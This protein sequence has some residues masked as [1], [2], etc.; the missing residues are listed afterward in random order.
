MTTWD[1]SKKMNTVDKFLDSSRIG[2]HC[3][4]TAIMNVCRYY[5]I[6]ISE[7]FC[8]GVGQGLGF[9]FYK[10]ENMDMYSFSGRSRDVVRNFFDNIGAEVF[11][12]YSMEGE[13]VWKQL[14]F[15]IKELGH[16]VIVKLDMD[17]MA[18]LK[19]RFNY[20]YK[21]QQ[22]EHLAVVTDIGDDYAL[23]SEY[24][25]KAP[26]RITKEELLR[27]MS[28]AFEEKA[29][30]NVFYVVTS[31]PHYIDYKK[32]A[33]MAMENNVRL[34]KYGFGSN[35]GLPGLKS[36]NKNLAMWRQ[37]KEEDFFCRILRM[38]Y[39]SFEKIGTGGGN[40]RRMYTR[41]L[42]E[43]AEFFSDAAF[44]EASDLYAKLANE[45]KTYSSLAIEYC[46]SVSGK[47]EIWNSI[48]NHL[49]SI[50]AMEEYAIDFVWRIIQNYGRK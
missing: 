44:T 43:C 40:F 37:T 4:S 12:G 50:V 33:I 38:S 16:P 10:D 20:V 7:D 49:N 47:D 34:F 9:S 28:E 36:F 45:W 1:K 21:I 6:D 39:F 32:T 24:Y 30:N 48:E 2:S 15:Y 22:S 25:D 19:E 42:N 35:M 26:V 17:S 41:F 18:Y 31:A 8:F 23:L 13:E 11:F 5:G 29:C 14:C 46:N 27:G 3:A